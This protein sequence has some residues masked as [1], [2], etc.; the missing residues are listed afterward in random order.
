MHTVTESWDQPGEG[1]VVSFLR[2]PD[3]GEEG[4]LKQQALAD[5]VLLRADDRHHCPGTQLRGSR[6]NAVPGKGSGTLRSQMRRWDFVGG[7]TVMISGQ[8]TLWGHLFY[9]I[10][11]TCVLSLPPFSTL[12]G[13]P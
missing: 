9:P 5:T 2:V 7:G 3:P 8:R 1:K 12:A 13:P 4:T 11:P 10:V 6:R